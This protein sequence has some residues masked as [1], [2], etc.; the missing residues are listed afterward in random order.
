[1]PLFRCSMT[2]NLHKDTYEFLVPGDATSLSVIRWVVT[3]LARAAGLSPEDV[4]QMETAVDEACSN[5]IDHAYKTMDHKPPLHIVIIN[6]PESFTVDVIDEGQSFD[7]GQYKEPKFPDH[8]LE[9]NTRGVGLFLIHRCIDEVEYEKLPNTRNRMRLIKRRHLS[10]ST[11]QPE[12]DDQASV[13]AE[14]PV[15]LNTVD[16]SSTGQTA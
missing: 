4:D 10:S 1:M 15:T 3:R 2:N 9:G 8:W 13:D 6:A 12:P 11:G 14:G 7:F 5:V 16:G